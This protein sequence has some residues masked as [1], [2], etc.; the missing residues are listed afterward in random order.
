LVSSEISWIQIVMVFLGLISGVG[1]PVALFIITRAANHREAMHNDL[2]ERLIHLDNC[3]DD[4]RNIV[5]S[6]G[7]TRED[8][9][10]FRAEINETMT[11]QRGAI[12]TE[13]AGLHDRIMRLEAPWFK[14]RDGT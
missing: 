2:S 12:S 3:L 11:R 9:E 6:K 10:R 13:T 14:G 5:L 1:T 4:V 8:F 7:V